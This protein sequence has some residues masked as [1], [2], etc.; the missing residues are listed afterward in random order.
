LAV[1][2]KE[3]NIWMIYQLNVVALEDGDVCEAVVAWIFLA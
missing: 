2:T 3:L 1:G